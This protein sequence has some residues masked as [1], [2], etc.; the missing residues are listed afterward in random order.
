MSASTSAGMSG[1]YLP[2][3]DEL[4]PSER[5]TIEAWNAAYPELAV[6]VDLAGNGKLMYRAT[7][8]PEWRRR[9]LELKTMTTGRK[10]TGNE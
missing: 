10:E 3:D 4:R 7:F 6:T 1:M 9:W 5:A 8:E 2:D